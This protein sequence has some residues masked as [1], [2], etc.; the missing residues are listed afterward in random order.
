MSVSRLKDFLSERNVPTTGKRKNELE[1]LARKAA[2]VYPVREICYH[3][4]ADSERKRRCVRTADGSVHDLNG[5]VVL[6]TKDLKKILF[7][8]L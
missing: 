1:T 2:N 4:H 5:R 3:A 7:A 8:R 6:W